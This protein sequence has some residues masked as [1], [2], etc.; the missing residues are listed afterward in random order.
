MG[1]SEYFPPPG[2]LSWGPKRAG[3][4]PGFG[5][6]LTRPARNAGI[7]DIAGAGVPTMLLCLPTVRWRGEILIRI[8]YRRI[9]DEISDRLNREMEEN[10]TIEM[11]T[12][13]G[14][15]EK[16]RKP[17]IMSQMWRG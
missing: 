10:C 1:S 7:S 4:Y 3:E 8:A 5:K 16:G 2:H 11:M 14:Q 15:Q 9:F 6:L 17:G 13:P 12:S